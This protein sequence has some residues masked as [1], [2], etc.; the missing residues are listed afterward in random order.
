MPNLSQS[1]YFDYLVVTKIKCI[2]TFMDHPLV[3]M[4]DSFRF[5]TKE[6]NP[7]AQL[8]Y[9]WFF[10]TKNMAG[11]LRIYFPT[12]CRPFWD[13]PRFI[14]WHFKN[15]NCLI[16]FVLFSFLPCVLL[17][18]IS[19]LRTSLFFL[20]FLF[21]FDK[22]NMIFVSQNLT[23]IL[24]QHGAEMEFSEHKTIQTSCFF[25]CAFTNQSWACPPML[26]T[27]PTCKF[28]S[29]FSSKV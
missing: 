11:S 8:T 29:C 13:K 26:S 10:F 17:Y 25:P 1:S 18:Y 6:K 4:E 14:N 2:P 22:K 21:F 7:L 27:V 3:W 15:Q 9:L 24:C 19:L 16:F 28:Y 5:F 20:F 23:K 12:E